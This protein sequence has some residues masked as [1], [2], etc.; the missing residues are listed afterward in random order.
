MFKNSIL[1]VD[2][3]QK[4]IGEIEDIFQHEYVVYTALDGANAIEI[5]KKYKPSLILLDSLDEEMP[6]FEVLKCLQNSDATKDIPVILLTSSERVEDEELGLLLGAVDFIR[7]PF[8]SIVV[9]YRVL[10]QMRLL[11]QKVAVRRAHETDERA[12]LMMD[13][14]PIACF[15]L[16]SKFNVMECNT[17]AVE[18]FVH[19]PDVF[20]ENSKQESNYWTR[21][22]TECS[23]CGNRGK[24]SCEGRQELINNAFSIIIGK[25]EDALKIVE[26][27]CTRALETGVQQLEETF[28]TLYGK[29]IPCEVTIVPVSYHGKMG[30]SC[31][32]RDLRETQ[33]IREEK[34]LR[35]MAE[36]E[37]QAKTRFLA[38]M[39]HE[40]RTPL[41]AIMGITEIQLQGERHLPETEEAFLMIHRSSNLLL[42]I[43]NDILDLSKVE[44][45]KMEIL[46]AP[47]DLVGLIAD[48]LQLNLLHMDSKEV[49]F[50]LYVDENLPAKL[51]GD[52]L[53]IKQILNNILSNAFKYT[54]I[55]TVSMSISLQKRDYTS[56]LLMS[57][58][59]TGQG[60]TKQQIAKLFELEFT[61]YNIRSNR[62]IEGTGL[63]MSIT[64][65]LIKIM[66]GEITVESEVGHGTTFNIY[67]PQIPE[68]SEII[69]KEE[70]ENL[71]NFDI[72][73]KVP[74]YI[75]KLIRQPMPYGRVLVVDDVES[76]L[77]VAKGLLNPYGISVEILESGYEAIKMI[78]DGEVYDIIFMD[79]M[80][81]GM[82][83]IETVKKLRKGGYKHPIIA[84]TAN[85]VKGQAELFLNSGFD[86]FV[87]KPIDISKLDE[88]LVRFIRD[89]ATTVP[90]Q[91]EG[92][93]LSEELIGFF[94]GDAQRAIDTI[95]EILKKRLLDK[96]ALKLY[97][98]HTHAVKSALINVKE[99]ELSEMAYKLE[100]AGRDSDLKTIKAET[101]RLLEGLRA[102][103]E[104]LMPSEEI[105]QPDEE[106]ELLQKLLSELHIACE[107]Y[108]IDEAENLLESLR[109]KAHSKQ[110]KALIHEISLQ[111]LHSNFEEAAELAKS[112]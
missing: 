27:H 45:G 95:E 50:E 19:E 2:D 67:L 89:K 76:N 39:S 82:D 93:L 37:N 51:I 48:T 13:A 31:Y 84:L 6:G 10:N 1:I 106:P 70:A 88:Y 43:I 66:Q 108:N 24:D 12:K 110:T 60:M 3:E 81:P 35:E 72:S 78:E 15:L 65:N 62:S 5:A 54:E 79:H 86:G 40:V 109:Q 58:K 91:S 101:A 111:L 17:A 97:T 57:I 61:R 29:L 7:K 53:R 32:L 85:A 44:A 4:T 23:T 68:G 71:R 105:D 9:R 16:N 41:N 100:Q 69:G 47:Y 87:S 59:D 30:F 112:V 46:P 14:L 98:I 63:G 103:V 83:G 18:L 38:R 94:I 34:R 77:Y 55:G 28:I 75:N 22:N 26:A 42:T 64:N 33:A 102:V 36:E 21:C 99:Y 11:N 73:I 25:P 80:M 90:A 104:N 49:K 92:V 56:G 8:R 20:A 74:S 107:D 52:E 96:E